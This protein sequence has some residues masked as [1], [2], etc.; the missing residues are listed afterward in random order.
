[1]RQAGKGRSSYKGF[2]IGRKGIEDKKLIRPQTNEK[3]K[4]KGIFQLLCC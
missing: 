1:M 3:N 4:R 2:S